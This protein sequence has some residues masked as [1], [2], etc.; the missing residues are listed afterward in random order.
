MT[1]RGVSVTLDYILM[2]M[3]GTV[4]LASVVTVSGILIGD[5]VDRG[6]EDELTAAGESL[7]GDVQAV[8][9]LYNASDDPNTSLELDVELPRHVSG[10]SYSISYNATDETLT[11][12]VAEPDISVSISVAASRVES[13]DNAFRGGPVTIVAEDGSITV[14]PS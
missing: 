3:I 8:E 7:A 6:I 2:L 5:Q 12:A 1:D 13:T 10:E 11:L 14:V 4:L 9:R